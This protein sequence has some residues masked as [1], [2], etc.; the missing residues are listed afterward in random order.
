[1]VLCLKFGKQN[2]SYTDFLPF[3]LCLY[4]FFSLIDNMLQRNSSSER[5]QLVMVV[6]FHRLF[7]TE[8]Y[9][10]LFKFYW[11]DVQTSLMQLI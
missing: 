4:Y 2:I 10:E 7:S 1:M 5:Q 11:V 6:C 8:S 3:S 9:V